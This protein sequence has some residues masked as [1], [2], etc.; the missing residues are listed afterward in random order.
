VKLNFFQR[1]NIWWPTWKGWLLL[2]LILVAPVI[3]WAWFGE[4]FLMRTGRVAADTLVVE[5]WIQPDG[6]HA[7]AAEYRS[8][9]YRHLVITGGMTGSKGT[10][11]RRSYITLARRELV[12]AG[13]APDAITPAEM[14]DVDS[15]RTHAMALA[16]RRALEEREVQPAGVNVFTAGAHARRSRL[17]YGKVFGP[18]VRVGVISWT[19]WDRTAGRPW[20]TSSERTLELIKETLGYTYELLLNSGR[21]A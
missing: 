20:W 4:T 18:T 2:F 19:A 3:T 13:I 14:P 21:P 5:S 7:A 8:G 9:G 1:R 17:V 12:D 11:R 15:Q 6:L 16:V 10:L